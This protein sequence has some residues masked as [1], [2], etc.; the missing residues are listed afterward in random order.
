MHRL[1]SYFF[2]FFIF[3][4]RSCE[5]AIGLLK[6]LQAGIQVEET[7]V[8]GTTEKL[9]SMPTAASALELDVSNF[10]FI[11]VSISFS[12]FSFSERLTTQEF[13]FFLLNLYSPFWNFTRYL[14]LS[15]PLPPLYFAIVFSSENLVWSRSVIRKM[16]IWN[17]TQNIKYK[18]SGCWM[19][20]GRHKSRV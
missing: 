18:Y 11:R 5:T 14:I 13:L 1:F 2:F 9:S 20:C 3:R 17:K 6:N 15:F 16:N 4:L 7:W 8:D 12:F 10:P 19:Y